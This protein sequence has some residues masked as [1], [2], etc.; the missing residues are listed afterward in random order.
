MFEVPEF[1]VNNQK[2]KLEA[3][4]EN[5]AKDL[6]EAIDNDRQNM[7]KWLPWVDDMQSVED[8]QDFIQYATVEMEKQKLLMLTIM[9]NNQ[10]AGLIDLHSISNVSKHASV[11]YWLSSNFQGHGITTKALENITKIGFDVLELHK[12]IVLAAVDNSKSKA[13]PERLG[14]K[15]EATLSQHILVRDKFMDVDLY[16]K[17]K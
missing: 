12:I 11:G 7:R 10:P 1:E 9:V 15:H 8:E 13:V 16:S 14:F 2:V 3:T 4:S 6:Y 5:H 17:I